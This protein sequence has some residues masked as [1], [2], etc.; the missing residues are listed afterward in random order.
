MTENGANSSSTS[1]T[2]YASHG[3]TMTLD[4]LGEEVIE[5]EHSA[6]EDSQAEQASLRILWDAHMQKLPLPRRYQRTS[7]LL[8][9]WAEECDYLGTK[10]EV[11]ARSGVVPSAL[12]Q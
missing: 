7:V 8:L 2:A 9:S 1:L 10:D 4:R 12:G 6:L 3:Y 11:C 5:S